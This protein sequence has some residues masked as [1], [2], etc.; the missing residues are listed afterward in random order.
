MKKLKIVFFFGLCI[1]MAT[2]ILLKAK[3]NKDTE[4][5]MILKHPKA[6]PYIFKKLQSLK[7]LNPNRPVGFQ[8]NL[9]NCDLS[10][11]NLSDR[12]NDLLPA[13]FDSRTKWPKTLPAKYDPQKIMELGKNPGLGIR[14]LHK[15]GITGRGISIAIMDSTL[16]VDHDEYKEQLMYYDEI[17]VSEKVARMHGTGAASIAVGKTIGV[18]PEAKLYYIA[19]THYSEK[20][21]GSLEFDFNWT[22]KVLRKFLDINRTLPKNRKIRVIALQNGWDETVKGWKEMDEAVEEAKKQGIFFVS[23]TLYRSH[24]FYFEGLGRNPLLDPDSLLSYEPGGFWAKGFYGN[25]MVEI[26]LKAYKMNQLLLF[27][28]DSRTSAGPSGDNDYIFSRYGGWSWVTPYIAGLYAL[29]C[30]VKPSLTP[31]LFWKTALATGDTIQITHENKNYKLGIIVNPL[32]LIEK[33]Q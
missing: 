9:K 10:N 6:E 15:K 18:A 33:L 22:A 24:G 21:D 1:F 4:V 13:H 32:K 26:D 28:M 7:S 16:L 25:N 3:E 27:P 19:E 12:L 5:K 8:I 30:Q 2:G 29:A 11:L 23:S 31:E 17:N 20:K 14:E